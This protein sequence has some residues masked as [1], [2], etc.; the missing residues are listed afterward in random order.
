MNQRIHC[1]HT[2]ADTM[3]EDWEVPIDT[4][5]IPM[6]GSVFDVIIVGGGPGGAAAAGYAA[7]DGCKV[8]LLEKAVWPRDKACGDAVGGKSLEHVTELGVREMIENTPHVRVTGIT[9]SSA[10]GTTISI[11]L[12]EDDFEKKSKEIPM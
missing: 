7:L 5:D 8:L 2:P 6:S 4:G 11:P 1:P 9:F 3:A 12:P 10:N